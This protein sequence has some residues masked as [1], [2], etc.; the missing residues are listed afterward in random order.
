[1]TAEHSTQ[2]DETEQSRNRSTRRRLLAGVGG[3]SLVA[4]AG[5]LGGGDGDDGDD[6]GNTSNGGDANGDDSTNG[7]NGDAPNGT[8]N[9][10]D[11]T[12]DD[13]TD[14]ST[15]D[16]TDSGD[17]S[18]PDGSD[19]GTD[20]EQALGDVYQWDE[21]YV[22][23]FTGPDGTGTWVYH[24][25]D[26]HMTFTSGGEETEL[27]LVDDTAYQ[28]NGGEC[29]Q[30]PNLNPDQYVPADTP[31]PDNHLD[32]T[33]SGT[34]M[35]DGQEVYVYEVDQG[36]FLVSV[37]SGYPVQYSTETGIVI[38]LHSWGDTDPISPPDMQCQ[39]Y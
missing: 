9:G 7:G 34:R 10:E 3:A 12:T 31:E 25:G 27:Y 23:E 20:E 36:E 8:E 37:D 19:N 26:W 13:G 15:D 17:D 11:N 1:M 22:M 35:H 38:D 21:S 2:T 29:F 30:I 33:S 5:C 18:D 4:V 6:N 32:L 39:S 24:E 28:V 14:D 16:G